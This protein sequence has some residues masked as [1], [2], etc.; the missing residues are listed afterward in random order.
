MFHLRQRF[1]TTTLRPST[2]RPGNAVLPLA[3][4]R[5]AREA[6]SGE[7]APRDPH[8]RDAKLARVEAALMIADEPL[9]A[10][11]LAEV[12]GLADAAE[13][14][15]FIERLQNLYDEDGSAFQVEEI[16]GGYQLLTRAQYHPWLARLKRTGH[17]LRL[18]PAALETLAVVA[19]RQPI[20]RAEVEKVR[21]VACGEVIR[22]LMEKGLVRVT[23][24]HDSLGRPQ[25]YGTTKKFLQ[26]FGLNT[27][28]DLPEVESL[29][30]PT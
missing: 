29:R 25:L 15:A 13:A 12:A 22:Q 20:M 11:K 2:R 5:G 8:A 1:S 24:R 18:S 6:A 9:P 7:P 10:R 26:S 23:G 16:A 28:K 4:S 3:A 27:L 30:P 19:Y 21:G 14:R 17:E